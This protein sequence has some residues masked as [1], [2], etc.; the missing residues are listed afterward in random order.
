MEGQTKHC[1]YCGGEIA[2]TA[3]KCKHCGKWIEKQCPACGE[4]MEEL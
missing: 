2:A 4:W 3:K 1:P